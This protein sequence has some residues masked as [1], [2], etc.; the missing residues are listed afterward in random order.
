MTTI[1]KNDY[2][3]KVLAKLSFENNLISSPEWESALG[4]LCQQ[5]RWIQIKLDTNKQ[6]DKVAQA[7]SIKSDQ[8]DS[9]MLLISRMVNRLLEIKLQNVDEHILSNISLFVVAAI[10]HSFPSEIKGALKGAKDQFYHVYNRLSYSVHRAEE[11][12]LQPW[13]LETVIRP[14]L[15]HF[16]LYCSELLIWVGKGTVNDL[17]KFMRLRKIIYQSTLNINNEL[18]STHHYLALYI[19][20][21]FSSGQPGVDVV[22][23]HFWEGADP[24]GELMKEHLNRTRYSWP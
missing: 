21:S 14:S 8:I 3:N 1:L 10:K 22:K 4:F 15:L 20:N 23:K 9:D 12:E 24:S 19:S 16:L 17:S 6:A 13:Q 5:S 18:E 11:R 7:L 2:Y